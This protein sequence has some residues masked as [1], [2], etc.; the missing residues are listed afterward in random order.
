MAGLLDFEDPNTVGALQ[1]GM[2]LLNAGGPSRMPVS[3]GQGIAQAGTGALDSMRQAR[4]DQA[5]TMMRKLQMEELARKTKAAQAAEMAKQKILSDPATDPRLR[6]YVEMG[7]DIS[8]LFDPTSIPEGGSLSIPGLGMMGGNPVV[9]QGAP[10]RIPPM[11][12]EKYVNGPKGEPYVQKEVSLDNGVSWKDE[13][14]SSP[15]F[16]KQVGTTVINAPAPTMS[17]VLDP[18]N[19]KQ[20]LK[21]DA[22][23]YRGGGMGSPGVVG[24]AGKEP[25]FAKKE[26]KEGQGKEMLSKE[27]DN[28][29]QHY[30]NLKDLGGMPSSEQNGLSNIASWTQSSGVGQLGGRMLGTKEQDERNAIK[31]T[32]LRLM[33][34]IKNATGMSAQQMNSNVELKTWLDSLGDPTQSFES[35]MEIIKNIEDA[36]L[37]DKK[38]GSPKPATDLQSAA[39]AELA[40]RRGGK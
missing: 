2:G 39:A 35:N 3:L 13:G 31:S 17:E 19:P 11:F 4:N 40:R 20:I 32:R 16:A 26:E 28:M 7:G 38:Q 8:K 29:R 10:K 6:Q 21:I 22:R 25:S 14:V 27:I 23:T 33:N 30:I 34:A 37:S 1:F 24:I 18:T 5:S 36:F 12:K 15:R 9:A